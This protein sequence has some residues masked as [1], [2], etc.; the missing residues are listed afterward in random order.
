MFIK[1]SHRR[2]L[3]FK[4]TLW[5]ED[6]LFERESP[7]ERTVFLLFTLDEVQWSGGFNTGGSV[8]GG[9]GVGHVL[10]VLVIF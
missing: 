5:N 9:V 1:L 7:C 10:S 4:V 8:I 2:L 3:F 6:K